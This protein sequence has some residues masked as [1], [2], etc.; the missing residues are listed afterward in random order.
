MF[1]S[2]RTLLTIAAI[3]ATTPLAFSNPNSQLSLDQLKTNHPKL[4][5]LE[6]NGRITKMVAPDLATG[7]TAKHS[8]Q[9]FLQTWS[10]ALGVNAKD[11]IAK[12]PFA[13]GHSIQPI[14]YN[15]ETGQYKFTGV[16]FKQTID[17]LPVYGSRLMVLSRNVEGN[18]IVNATVDLRDVKNFKKSPRAM[19]N[20]ALALMAAATRFG[21]AVTTTQP[22]LMVFA[23]TQSE[24]AEPRAALVF[25]AKVGGNWDP[26]TYQKAEL[27]VDALT[28]EV[29]HERNLILHVDGNVSGMATESSGAD[30]CD[31][32]SSAGLPYAKVTLGGNTAYADADGDFSINGSGNI[33][34]RLEGQWFNVNNQSGSDSSITQ[35]SNNPYIVHNAANNS[36]T[37]RAEVNAYLQS[38]IVRDFALTYNPDY[39]TIA[40]Q[41][42]FPVNVNIGDSCNAY[43]D[44]IS[45]Q[46]TFIVQVAVVATP[47][48]RSL[49]TT[50]MVIIS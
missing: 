14:M 19:N 12:G 17:G 35:S 11:F 15:Q 29:L 1:N 48:S 21:V 40:N 31:I 8:A 49:F 41:T 30:V 10:Y 20:N 22:K 9:N 27:V 36:G 43:Y 32:E 18:P 38:N 25:E 34:S 2:S 46:L 6:E 13:D 16:Y 39:P 4:R 7:K 45:L 37:Y 5:L 33:T 23:G 50:N 42:S 3:C 47:H 44:S 28:G 26:S 24:H